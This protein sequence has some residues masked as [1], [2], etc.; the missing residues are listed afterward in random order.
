MIFGFGKKPASI[1]DRALNEMREDQARKPVVG[2]ILAAGRGE[3]FDP[4]GEKSKLLADVEGMPALGLAISSI[5]TVLENVV[6]VVRQGPQRESIEAIARAFGATPVICADAA[7]GMGHSLAW[8]VSE[9]QSRFDPRGLIVA[10]GDMPFVSSLTISTLVAHL[11]TPFDMAVPRFQGRMGNPVAFG[12][13]Y[14]EALGRLSGD[15]GA[16]SLIDSNEPM[17]VDVA[18]PG[19]LQDIDTPQDL[20]ALS[21]KK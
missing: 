8:G 21:A 17:F 10:L 3:R 16:R 2:L 4:S 11:R 13:E 9:A 7:S 20:A 6:V 19:I 14:F 1:M 12:S 5:S 18:D 15:R